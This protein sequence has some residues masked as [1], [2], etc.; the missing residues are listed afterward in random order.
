ML[1]GSALGQLRSHWPA[2]SAVTTAAHS[3]LDR[4]SRPV[5][6]P[7]SSPRGHAGSHTVTRLSQ[8]RHR[9]ALADAD[10]SCLPPPSP[11]LSS[12]SSS[13][14]AADRS[15]ASRSQPSQLSPGALVQPRLRPAMVYILH[16]GRRA[17]CSRHQ[18][19]IVSVRKL[20]LAPHHASRLGASTDLAI[21]ARAGQRLCKIGSRSHTAPIHG[22]L[23]PR[24]LLLL[25]RCR[26]QGYI[27]LSCSL[28]ARSISACPSDLPVCFS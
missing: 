23:L 24:T 25:S 3:D 21:R 28:L 13:P 5:T 16:P 6:P 15:T 2:H 18:R 26:A 4:S 27:S 20:P 19:A 22:H 9:T 10:A 14:A 12:S 1:A 17:L 11:S 8:L 7:P